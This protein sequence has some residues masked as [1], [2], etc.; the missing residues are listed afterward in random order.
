MANVL[1]LSETKTSYDVYT[2]DM[3]FILLQKMWDIPKI[4][5]EFFTAFRS[6]IFDY[7]RFLTTLKAS[8]YI[9][10]FMIIIEAIWK[11]RVEF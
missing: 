10:F 11:Y 2:F 3:K 1:G 4:C 9:V 8:T 6:D 5:T 7:Q